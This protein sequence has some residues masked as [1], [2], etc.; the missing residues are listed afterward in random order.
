MVR[1]MQDPGNTNS[2]WIAFLSRRILDVLDP[3]LPHEAPV[4]LVDFPN[5]SNVGDSAIWLGELRYLEGRHAHIDY[6]CDRATFSEAALRRKMPR[7]LILLHGGGSFGDLWPAQQ[8]F[9]EKIIETFKDYRIIQLPQSMHFQNPVNLER[10]RRVLDS[11]PRLTLLMRD[12]KSLETARREFRAESILCPD[13]AFML[14]PLKRPQMPSS[15]ILWLMRTD[16]ETR[17]FATGQE[18]T[19]DWIREPKSLWIRT[20]DFLTRQ[21]TERPRGLSDLVPVWTKAAERVALERVERGNTLLSRSRVFIT[22][23]LH[24]HILGLLM[25]I[26]HV[27]LDNSYGKLSKFRETWTGPC[28][29]SAV[30]ATPEEAV[31]RARQFLEAEINPAFWTAMHAWRN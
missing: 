12:E 20:A 17:G 7:G 1:S 26:P 19:A 8:A 30:A 28:S 29:L 16:H 21:L 24:A 23:R 22:D 6:A 13:M 9:R 31:A 5:H 4:A 10:A 25:G 14:G 3:F 2:Q 15:D 27:I 18:N 11:H